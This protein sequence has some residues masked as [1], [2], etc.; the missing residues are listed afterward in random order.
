[1]F[2]SDKKIKGIFFRYYKLAEKKNAKR[3]KL[4]AEK[5]N[6][7]LGFS[8]NDTACLELA[9]FIR[10]FKRVY[11]LFDYINIKYDKIK[12][13]YRC[14]V[15]FVKGLEA[16]DLSLMRRPGRFFNPRLYQKHLFPRYDGGNVTIML[17][18]L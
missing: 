13:C 10:S 7:L 4:N 3:F 6:K 12:K 2:I 18:R 8:F 15:E 5:L 1:M 17:E 11:R 9:R 16:D 14:D